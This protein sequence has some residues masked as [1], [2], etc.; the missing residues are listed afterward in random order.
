MFTLAFGLRIFVVFNPVI[1]DVSN[2]GITP[3]VSRSI[4]TESKMERRLAP[5]VELNECMQIFFFLS[6]AAQSHGK[7]VERC[8]W[9]RKARR[10]QIDC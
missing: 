8:D 5:D 2:Y 4:D 10:R 6:W 9:V 1:V 7:T 3:H